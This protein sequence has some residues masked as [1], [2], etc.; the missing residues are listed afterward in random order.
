MKMAM[1]L[2]CS[3]WSKIMLL[4]SFEAIKQHSDPILKQ[5][6]KIHERITKTGNNVINHMLVKIKD[7]GS[8]NIQKP[9]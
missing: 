2:I 4:N 6:T 3:I 9:I 1:E 8:R 7:E 5:L